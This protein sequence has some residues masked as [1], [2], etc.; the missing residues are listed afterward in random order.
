MIE[1][2]YI[3][4]AVAAALFLVRLVVGPTVPDRVIAA[5]GLLIAVVCGILVGAADL[6]APAD[7]DTV[8]VVA[9]IAFIATGVLARF[10]E[11]R[12]G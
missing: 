8:L 9:L 12:G 1:I 4:L 11:Q 7:L 10:V 3:I 6:N 2:A 5:D